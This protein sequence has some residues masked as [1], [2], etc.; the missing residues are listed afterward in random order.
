MGDWNGDNYEQIP[1]AEKPKE[2]PTEQRRA[3]LYRRI[4]E[5]GHP[6][7]FGTDRKEAF[8]EEYGISF[9]QVY[10]DLEAVK[11]FVE[12]TIG[13]DHVT[14]ASFVFEKAITELIQQGEFEKAAKIA[15]EEANWLESRGIIDKSA[16][17]VEVTW[18]ELIDD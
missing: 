5:L 12:E 10:Y 18:R 4:K 11:Q 8:A 9:R 15:S 1:P 16:E 3:D 7:L 2:A 6:T 13:Q 14:D 17:E